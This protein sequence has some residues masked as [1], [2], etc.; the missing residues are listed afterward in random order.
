MIL[1]ANIV[2]SF[3]RFTSL[4]SVEFDFLS[5]VSDVELES[6]PVEVSMTTALFSWRAM[7]GN[8]YDTLLPLDR[9]REF[10]GIL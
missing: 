2:D 5:S 10:F 4:S 7:D 3:G 8:S 1:L 9:D 6:S